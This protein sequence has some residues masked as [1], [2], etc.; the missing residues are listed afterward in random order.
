MQ[1]ITGSSFGLRFWS[2]GFRQ[3]PFGC[4]ALSSPTSRRPKVETRCSTMSHPTLA[5][6]R[7]GSRPT[8]VGTVYVWIV[9]VWGTSLQALDRAGRPHGVLTRSACRQAKDLDT[10]IDK[11]PK[12]IE[13]AVIGAVHSTKPRR[14]PS[15]LA[16][17]AGAALVA[18]RGQ[19]D[20]PYSV[21]PV[22]L[23]DRFDRIQLVEFRHGP[24]LAMNRSVVDADD[25]IGRL[26]LA[27]DATHAAGV[28]GA[29]IR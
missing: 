15:A 21:A 25:E 3:R 4:G 5:G 6:E 11:P 18:V 20:E 9:H 8:W 10:F 29:R 17:V 12:D 28:G 26:K 22:N 7:A 1:L 23:P 27:H 24:A 13:L 2:R 19:L 14:V 16:T